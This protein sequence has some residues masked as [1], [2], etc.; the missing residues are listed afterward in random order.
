[1]NC[2][3][4]WERLSAAIRHSGIRLRRISG[5]QIPAFAG[6]TCSGDL[7]S[8]RQLDFSLAFNNILQNR[9]TETVNDYHY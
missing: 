8:F 9:A 4:L 3:I 1:M 5:I 6:M 2:L 7:L